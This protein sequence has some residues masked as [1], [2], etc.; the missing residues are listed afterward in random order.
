MFQN[1]YSYFPIVAKTSYQR[2][3]S[4]ILTHK[5]FKLNNIYWTNNYDTSILQL[6]I[7]KIHDIL[8]CISFFHCCEK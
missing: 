8:L 3:S 4:I 5:R 6:V 7:Y 1:V 2:Y